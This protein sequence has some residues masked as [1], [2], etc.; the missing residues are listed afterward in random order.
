[1]DMPEPVPQSQDLQGQPTTGWT[2]P[3][4]SSASPPAPGY[5]EILGFSLPLV[6]AL[7]TYA[8]HNLVDAAFVGQLGTAP[9]AALAIANF[10][11]ISGMVVLLGLIRSA[12]AFLSQSHGAGQLER[13]GDWVGQYQWVALA[14]LPILLV[15]MQGFPWVAR[16]ADLSPATEADARRFLAIRVWEVP[17]ALTGALYA[18]LHTATGR[19]VFPMAVQWS[20]VGLNAVLNYGLVLGHF[21]LPRLGLAG[22]ATATLI[23]QVCGA[24]IMVGGTHGSA[25]RRAYRL[26]LLARPRE[27]ALRQLLRLGLP[28]GLGDGLE[29]VAFLAFYVIVGQLGEAALAASNIGMQ[30]THLLFMPGIA[31]GIA[32]ASLVGRFIGMGAPRVGRVAAHRILGMTVGYMG[33][34]GIPLWFYGETIA[35]WFIADAEVVRQAGWVFKVMAVYQV[36]DA[37]GIVLRITLSG[38]GDTR[39]PMASVA[40][41][42]VFVMIPFSWG[43]SRWLAPGIVGAWVGMLGYIVVL[44]IVLL[45]R[46]ERGAWMRLNVI[47]HGYPAAAAAIPHTVAARRAAPSPAPAE[48]SP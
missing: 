11:Y 12:M 40:A 41:C 45:W 10:T 2:S 5:G 4:G 24:A 38:A 35:G 1:M 32:G 47:R 20:T 48:K 14:S 9:L 22:S 30:V 34:L 13:L 43:L 29:V 6:L 16:L 46:F 7:S 25:L 36:F 19:S 21:G 23:A 26:R 3:D 37:A 27:A 39:F 18:T 33:V 31:M 8:V 42:A 28:Q 17:F 15:L 44:G